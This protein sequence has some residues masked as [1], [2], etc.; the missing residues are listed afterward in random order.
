MRLPDRIFTDGKRWPVS[1]N[2]VYSLQR[3]LHEQ[4][5]GDSA[6]KKRE[7]GDQLLLVSYL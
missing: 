6:S 5:G 3:Q 4:V 2:W 1:L 7:A